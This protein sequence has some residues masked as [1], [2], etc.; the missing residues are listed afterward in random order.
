MC[1][2]D[3]AAGMFPS[4]SPILCLLAGN[5]LTLS[6]QFESADRQLRLNRQSLIGAHLRPFYRGEDASTIQGLGPGL[7]IAKALVNAQGGEIN[8]QSEVGKGSTLILR[9]LRYADTP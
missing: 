3:P 8:V 1:R 7:P 2:F 4:R 5:I 9:F 6:C